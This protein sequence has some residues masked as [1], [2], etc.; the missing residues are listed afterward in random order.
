MHLIF[1]SDQREDHGKSTQQ[2]KKKAMEW[3]PS[4]QEAR[5]AGQNQPEIRSRHPFHPS[6]SASH[7][8]SNNILA[9]S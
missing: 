9:T 1:L 2:E 8:Q 5:P 7:P 4:A 3:P 6:H